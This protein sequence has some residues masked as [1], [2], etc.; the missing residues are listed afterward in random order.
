[1]IE[2]GHPD[3]DLL[4]R[5][6]ALPIIN[7]N[8]A[9]GALLSPMLLCRI[10]WGRH[11]YAEAHTQ[12]MIPSTLSLLSGCSEALSSSRSTAVT[13]PHHTWADTRHA[14]SHLWNFFVC[15]LM[16]RNSLLLF[17]TNLRCTFYCFLD[18]LNDFLLPIEGGKRK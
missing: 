17:V 15:A 18:L 13:T 16:S 4:R 6:I 3:T 2:L 5:P 11:V 9:E 7:A 8:R 10:R 1:M 12:P 14:A